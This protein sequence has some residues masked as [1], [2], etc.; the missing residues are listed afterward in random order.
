MP[1]GTTTR[2]TAVHSCSH[3]LSMS[4]IGWAVGVRVRSLVVAGGGGSKAAVERTFSPL[5]N[6]AAALAMLT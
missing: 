1:S 5:H 3:R 4:A 2:G 6:R